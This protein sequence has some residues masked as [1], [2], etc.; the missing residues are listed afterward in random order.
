MSNDMNIARQKV[1]D[2]VG[3]ARSAQSSWAKLS[4]NKRATFLLKMRSH[5][6]VNAERIAAGIS[7]ATGKTRIDA[8]STEVLSTA[9]ALSFYATNAKKYLQRKRLKGGGLL[10][11]NK[12]PYL[13][14]APFGIIGIISPWNYPFAIPFHEIAMAL[15]AGNA[16]ILK[17]A[18]V[19]RSV[20]DIIKETVDAS[21]LPAGIFTLIDLPGCEA[22]DAF[23]NSGIDKL[24]FTGSVS[25]GKEL[26]A[27]AA[28]NL[29]PLSLELGGNDAMIVCGDADLSRAANGALWAGMSN[30]GQ[31][32]AAVER[33]YVVADVYDQFMD[34]LKMK[35]ARLRVGS[36]D[37]FVADIG[38][39]TTDEQFEKVKSIIDDGRYVAPTIVENLR[40]E[41]RISR[42]EV[43]GPVI[44]VAKV[45]SVDEA[46]DAANNSSL[47]LTASVWTRNK[48]YARTIASR[49]QVGS[50]MINDHLMSHGLAETPWGGFKES[51][52]GRTHG[53]LG[54]EEMTQPRVVIEDILPLVKRNMWWYPHDEG[55]YRGLLG[56]LRFLYPQNTMQRIRASINLLKVFRRTFTDE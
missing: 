40:S 29:L 49:L 19:T 18:S 25:V 30:A 41:M 5:I 23:I 56:A 28:N 9:M 53:H 31:S 11:V 48:H 45:A 50:V 36:D 47:G 55:V 14:R 34:L 21:G 7:S 12:R 3:L 46:V 20:G 54:L 10:T 8:L 27:K 17:V 22:G 26:M 42:E 51:G 33:I 2:A 32:C 1:Q 13:E 6:S 24:F 52:I 4:F 37:N 15:M 38:S 39:L 16:V 35:T 43:F 44:A